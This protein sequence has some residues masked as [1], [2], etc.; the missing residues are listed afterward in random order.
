MESLYTD[1]RKAIRRVMRVPSRTHSNILCHIIQN[2]PPDILL[3]QRFIHFFYRGFRSDNSVVRSI[4]SGA[5]FIPSQIG[6]NLRYIFHKVNLC[7]N[8]VDLY[9][10]NQIC[11]KLI[12]L[13]ASDWQV[14]D[15]MLGH[16][17]RE[18]I[19]MRDNLRKTFYTNM[20]VLFYW[21]TY[22]HFNLIVYND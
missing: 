21:I 14:D 18:I 19:H 17:I 6:N 16:Q 8:D 10:P 22:P 5:L 20:N 11:A 13:W 3:F 7:I 4:F 9:C 12:S 2:P 15:I 1:L